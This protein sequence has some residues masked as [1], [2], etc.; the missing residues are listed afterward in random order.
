M[1]PDDKTLP[2]NVVSIESRI[3]KVKELDAAEAEIRQQREEIM[4]SLQDV[5]EALASKISETL[6]QV[7]GVSKVS[8]AT[9]SPIEGEPEGVGQFEKALFSVGTELLQRAASA[10][11]GYAPRAGFVIHGRDQSGEGKTMGMHLVI[12]LHTVTQDNEVVYEDTSAIN[13]S[14]SD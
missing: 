11:E 3:K 5:D 4:A 13:S 2:E 7:H 14:S 1:S 6:A 10:E 9:Y 12:A 8:K